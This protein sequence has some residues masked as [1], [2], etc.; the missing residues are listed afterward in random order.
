MGDWNIA[1]LEDILKDPSVSL[2]GM[3]FDQ[4]DVFHLFGDNPMAK[5]DEVQGMADNL[6]KVRDQY[7]QN[8][9]TACA[10]GG[11]D[12]YVVV[13]FRDYTERTAFLEG[14]GLEDNRYQSG[15][16]LQ[17]LLKPAEDSRATPGE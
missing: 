13:V 7:R 12:F 3:G 4:A 11:T 17:A 8:I 15:A 2:E 14:F 10:K 5:A 1:R 9:K 6:R 16:A